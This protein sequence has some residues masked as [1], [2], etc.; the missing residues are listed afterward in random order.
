MNYEVS[1]EYHWLSFRQG[2]QTIIELTIDVLLSKSKE[3]M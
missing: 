2:Y 3:N 1:R